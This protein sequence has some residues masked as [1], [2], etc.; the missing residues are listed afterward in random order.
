MRIKSNPRIVVLPPSLI[1]SVYT[2]IYGYIFY[3]H[4]IQDDLMEPV[5]QATAVVMATTGL[6]TTTEETLKLWTMD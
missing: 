3:F 1:Q 4:P 6:V 5:V 2:C